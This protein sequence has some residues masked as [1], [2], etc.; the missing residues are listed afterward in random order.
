MPTDYFDR[1]YSALPTV[2][3]VL[4]EVHTRAG[5][6]ARRRDD[7]GLATAPENEP[8]LTGYV[9]KAT[10]AVARRTGRVEALVTLAYALG[11][12]TAA[13]PASALSGAITSAAVTV[14]DTPTALEV[15]DRSHRLDEAT[16]TGTPTRC[17]V[18]GGL[19]YLTPTPDAACTVTLTLA[20]GSGLA[21]GS[22][23]AE[24]DELASTF[25]RELQEAVVQHVLAS[26]Y[27]SMGEDKLSGRHAER[28]EE[29]LVHF[30]D[31]PSGPNAVRL[32]YRPH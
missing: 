9:R 28:F 11:V 6:T 27:D 8:E 4:T 22:G 25:P 1:E 3:A 14:G 12:R 26:W 18:A 21:D 5:R 29:E 19:L 24:G 23:A 16:A 13:L 20:S 30:A 17:Y 2:R 7:A 32:R 10:R 15:H 31:D